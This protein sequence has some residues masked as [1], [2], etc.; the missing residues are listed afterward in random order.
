MLADSHSSS[1]RSYREILAQNN[2][3]LQQRP[4]FFHRLFLIFKSLN[5]FKSHEFHPPW[6][7]RTRLKQKAPSHCSAGTLTLGNQPGCERVYFCFEV[8]HSNSGRI[9]SE[10]LKEKL[11]FLVNGRRTGSDI[12][13]FLILR[14]VNRHIHPF[15]PSHT[16]FFWPFWAND[17]CTHIQKRRIVSISSLLQGGE[18]HRKR[19]V[20]AIL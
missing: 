14:A 17:L 16:H 1:S 12:E 6:T 7:L 3:E 13:A 8:S 10:L 20:F 5:I 15:T 11:Q 9:H 18:F 2:K 19:F 4:W